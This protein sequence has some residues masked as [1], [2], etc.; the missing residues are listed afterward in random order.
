MHSNT[1]KVLTALHSF[2]SRNRRVSHVTPLLHNHALRLSGFGYECKMTYSAHHS[3]GVVTPSVGC[4]VDLHCLLFHRPTG[5]WPP[6]VGFPPLPIVHSWSRYC[7]VTFNPGLAAPIICRI[8]RLAIA[9]DGN[10]T[11]WFIF[12][13]FATTSGPRTN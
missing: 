4:A 3:T 9:V 1:F 6:S 2:S 7:P 12:K 8:A 11:L 10:F 13:M 5:L